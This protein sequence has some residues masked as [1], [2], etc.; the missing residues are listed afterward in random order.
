M[1][2]GRPFLIT[3]LLL[4]VSHTASADVIELKTG[5]RVEGAS[6][7]VGAQRVTIVVGGQTLTFDR[8]KVRAIYL[9]AAPAQA[10]TTPSSATEALKALRAVQSITAGGVNL[11]EY[12]TRVADTRIK[13]DQYLAEGGK[14]TPAGAAMKDARDLYS[15]AARAWSR[16]V[17][18]RGSDGLTFLMKGD[19][20]P[21]DRCPVFME[22]VS[23]LASRQEGFIKYGVHPDGTLWFKADGGGLS[24]IWSCAADKIAEAEKL[25]K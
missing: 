21:L 4:T 2:F 11:R 22:Y 17:T 24:V 23:V 7:Q 25:A 12:S 8:E 1:W 13:V 15:V 5:E 19:Y 10:Q 14:D 9:G 16:A 6:A 20:D 3:L 18:T